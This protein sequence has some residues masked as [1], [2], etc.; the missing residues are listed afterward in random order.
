MQSNIVLK[1]FF[2]TRKFFLQKFHNT[3][4]RYTLL[5]IH[6]IMINAGVHTNALLLI[7]DIAKRAGASER[8]LFIKTSPITTWKTVHVT[9]INICQEVMRLE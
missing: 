3:D 6:N 5:I 2:S 1:K 4:L 7:K 9:F 8:A